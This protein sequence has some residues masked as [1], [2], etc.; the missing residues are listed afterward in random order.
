MPLVASAQSSVLAPSGWPE[1]RQGMGNQGRSTGRGAT[2]RAASVFYGP[3]QTVSSLVSK[4][5]NKVDT[6][7]PGEDFL[8]VTSQ[9][10]GLTKFNAFET[11]DGGSFSTLS[12][13]PLPAVKGFGAPSPDGSAWWSIPG[14]GVLL[15][16]AP[17]GVGGMANVANPG[18][19][20][21]GSNNTLYVLNGA[22]DL[23]AFSGG[24]DGHAVGT[25][26]WDAK[27]TVGFIAGPAVLPTG[28]IVV[29]S[30]DGSLSGYSPT[31]ALLWNVKPGVGDKAKDAVT[32]VKM[33]NL[34]V[35]ADGNV[36][37]TYTVTDKVDGHT[38]IELIAISPKGA[39]VGNVVMANE[40]A[41]QTATVS[42]L[43]GSPNNSF[44]LNVN[45]TNRKF[46][47]IEFIDQFGF[48]TF[49]P[50]NFY[51]GA[52]A[53]GPTDLIADIDTTT[54]S[55]V[56]LDEFDDVQFSTP[57]TADPNQ[58]VIDSSG[59]ITVATVN[60]PLYSFLSDGTLQNGFA[61]F[62][63]SPSL[64]ADGLDW[65]PTKNP[66]S[67]LVAMK[68]SVI[69][70]Q[71]G[72][73]AAD[74]QSSS[75]SSPAIDAAG[76]VYYASTGGFLYSV[77]GKLPASGPSVENWS[78]AAKGSFKASP[79]LGQDGQIFIG[80]K[81]G[82]FYGM[83]PNGVNHFTVKA[84]GPISSS[85][86]VD[87]NNVAYVGT[88]NGF[89]AAYTATGTLQFQVKLGTGIVA[90]PA[91]GDDGTIYIGTTDGKFFAVTNKG[92][93]K[94]SVT[95]GASIGSSAAIAVNGTIYVG[96]DDARLY[97]INPDGTTKWTF[98]TNGMVRSSPSV[99]GDGTIYV[100]SLDHNV[101]AINPNGLPQWTFLTRGP[102]VAS[103][104]IGLDGKIH[105]GSNDGSVYIIE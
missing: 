56:L 8:F 63:A 82:N 27:S 53:I 79:I 34:V 2:G 40:A 77:P 74:S 64:S 69:I 9:F 59:S 36:H 18:Q 11:L 38:L 46:K 81:A 3:G 103:P 85:A 7:H 83:L 16:P 5:G 87:K 54:H 42:D 102:V 43:V 20:A 66:L 50:I 10:N 44:V 93:V 58:V 6:R 76:N 1:F 49:L 88:E 100:G 98:P 78:F 32:F 15:V 30:S 31:G 101:Y 61:P 24:K 55:L 21:I 99:G 48:R 104:A 94:W 68:N 25:P 13:N 33:G 39:S 97:A 86:A 19:P 92:A 14:F 26:L 45:D 52:P 70:G 65:T 17:G 51:A 47:G 72:T 60:G 62:V 4:G 90:S 75:V 35:G 12:N 95:T 71:A 73:L 41:G 29:G 84:Q 67:K 57:F 28:Q 23:Q 80:D 96:S 37:L 91:I 22:K 105:I 89:L